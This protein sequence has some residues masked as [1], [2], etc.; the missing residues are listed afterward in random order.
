MKNTFGLDDAVIPIFYPSSLVRWL[1]TQGYD[2]L[3]LIENTAIEAK[4]IDAPE[5][6]ITFRQHR[7][8]IGNAL[9]L[10]KNPHLGLYFGQQLQL[11]AMGMVGYAAIS[12]DSLLQ[13][14][15]TISKYIK[16][17]APL[18]S[19]DMK[20]K[21]DK[22]HVIYHEPLDYGPLRLFFYEGIMAAS[23]EMFSMMGIENTV[24]GKINLPIS[25]PIDWHRHKHLVR[26]PVSFDQSQF[27]F[28][29]PLSHL[30][31]KSKLA[32][33]VT[34]KNAKLIC[35]QELQHSQ[36]QEGLV[37]RIN[38]LISQEDDHFP[39]LT[40]AAKILCVSSRTL[41]R[42]LLKLDTSYQ[43]LLDQAREKKAIKL[44][45]N[46][47]FTIQEIAIKLGYNDPSN[48]GR[49]FRKWTGKSPGFYRH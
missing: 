14:M 11:T 23:V 42:E 48:F 18:I 29:L 4:E 21:G 6:L 2:R 7:V 5:V 22:M 27:E 24:G 1:E 8:L 39:S 43:V 38:I 16:L 10:T 26:L 35:E 36:V 46:S 44:L 47:V 20:E 41:R 19:M 31:Q 9:R 34:A 30:K 28:I 12:S 15:E 45:K 40:E 13:S 33:P 49:A 25:E 17:R 37:N 32:D 3:A